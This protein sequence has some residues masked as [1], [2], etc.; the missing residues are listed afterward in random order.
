MK[1]REL[2][3]H[4][5]E[6]IRSGKVNGW[7]GNPDGGPWLQRLE[8]SFRRYHDATHAIAVSSGTAAMHC[9]LLALGVGTHDK[10]VTTAYTHI[11]GVSPIEMCGGI[12]LFVDIEPRGFNMN[13]DGLKGLHKEKPV[14]IIASH[15][16]GYPCDMDRIMEYSKGAKVVEDASQALGA[17]YHGKRVG[18]LGDIA[19][20]SVGGD[21]TKSFTTGEGG[22]IVTND[23][24]LADKCRALRNHGDRYQK[25]T[26]LC[27][28][29]RM[30]EIQA[31]VGYYFFQSIDSE[32]EWQRER[33]MYILA[34]A[35]PCLV[36][37]QQPTKE[38]EPSWYLLG[39]EVSGLD[40]ETVV[41]ILHRSGVSQGRP[42]QN[43]SR[44]YRELIYQL[45]LYHRYMRKC[46]CAEER[47]RGSI[48]ID[49]HRRPRSYSEIDKMLNVVGG[50][51]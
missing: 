37:L 21:L 34:K 11:G 30:S 44:G 22:L 36:S 40:P 25:K 38:V 35:P 46:P 28:N 20:F 27:Y 32:I 14:V 3:R 1:K 9:A 16:L 24:E 18:T 23:D 47:T 48:W 41:Q 4:F 49:Y 8:T 13:P 6:M 33:A 17:R 50:I 43:I 26:Y 51:R 45:P 2:A 7:F 42:R 15:Q 39:F 10:V 19:I 12:P 29:Y 31:L 5:S